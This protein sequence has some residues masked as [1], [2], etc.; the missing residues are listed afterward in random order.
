MQEAADL[1][2]RVHLPGALLEATDEGHRLE[3]LACGVRLGEVGHQCS[4]VLQRAM[5]SW[6]SSSDRSVRSR[7]RQ[8]RGGL[9]RAVPEEDGFAAVDLDDLDVVDASGVGEQGRREPG[10]GEDQPVGAIGPHEASRICASG[11]LEGA[12][13][14]NT[15][16]PTSDAGDRVDS[17]LRRAA[18][19]VVSELRTDRAQLRPRSTAAGCISQA[20]AAMST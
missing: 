5:N 17:R 20:A 9:R 12:L 15:L 1:G 6:A 14:W 16:R 2:A 13:P 3:P 18:A 4:T 11:S 7:A 8:P 19:V 10:A